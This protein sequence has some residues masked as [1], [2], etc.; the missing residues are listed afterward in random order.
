MKN[1]WQIAAGLQKSLNALSIILLFSMLAVMFTQV[2][3]RVIF[4]SSIIWSE[5]ALRFMF[6]WLVFLGVA[7]AVYYNDLSRFEL[8]QEKLP[9]LGRKIL[10]TLI[11]LVGGAILYCAAV[12]ALPLVKRQMNQ[13]ATALPIKMGVVYLVIPVSASIGLFYIALHIIALWTNRPFAGPEDGG[14]S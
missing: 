4:E 11:H 1:L 3:L 8:L 6:I 2:L 13:L 12:G 5:E 10:N 14:A 9:P 7:T